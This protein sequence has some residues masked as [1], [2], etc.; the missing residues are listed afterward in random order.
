M[1]I[2][3]IMKFHAI[4]IKIKKIQKSL[5]DYEHHENLRNQLE[6]YKNHENIK[7]QLE[8]YEKNKKH[9]N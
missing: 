7:N 8:N 4:I 3:K 5:R 1:N 6:N 2:M 9:I